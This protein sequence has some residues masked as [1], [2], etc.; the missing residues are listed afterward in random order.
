M[1]AEVN[2]VLRPGGR[3]AI[4][5][6]GRNVFTSALPAVYRL[7]E[8]VHWRRIGVGDF[9]EHYY[10]EE[11]MEELFAAAGFVETKVNRVLVRPR[12]P[13][14]THLRAGAAGPSPGVLQCQYSPSILRSRKNQPVRVRPQGNVG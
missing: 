14:Q 5:T 11:E 10:T 9:G 13:L 2:R 12:E 6:L 4:C 8:R 3:V 1:L 7:G